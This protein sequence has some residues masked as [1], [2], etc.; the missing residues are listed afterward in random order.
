MIKKVYIEIM[1]HRGEILVVA[2]LGYTI[3]AFLL[4]YIE[5]FRQQ[6]YHVVCLSNW[7]YAWQ[8]L[9]IEVERIHFPFQRRLGLFHWPFWIRKLRR[10]LRERQWSLVYTHTPI[11]SA[12]VRLAARGLNPSIPVLY[13]AHGFHFHQ[14]GHWLVNRI[15]FAV[16]E[17]LSVYSSGIITLNHFD[18][19]QAK[20]FRGTAPVFYV[21][22][23][24][25][26][27]VYFQ[28]DETLGREKRLQLSLEPT[29]KILVTIADLIPRKQVLP[30]VLLAAQLRDIYS[31]FSW[32]L[33]GEGS[34]A[35]QLRKEIERLSL[36]DHFILAGWQADVHSWLAMADLFVLLSWQEGLPRSVLEAGACAVPVLVSNIRGN[37]DLIDQGKNGFLIPPSLLELSLEYLCFPWTETNRLKECGM[38]LRKKIESRFSLQKALDAHTVIFNNYLGE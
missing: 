5:W 33:I 2:T 9:P 34:L 35:G 22:G 12:L 31:D 23:V 29:R 27:T 19:H 3:E 24:G 17:R 36:S 25:V 6:G 13:E 15:Y 37:R 14:Y 21:P 18:Y 26:D 32:F 38:N 28:P 8:R 16:E 20:K 11:A 4:P 7:E 10:I 30:L 1:N